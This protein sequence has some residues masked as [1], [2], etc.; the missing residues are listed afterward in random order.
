MSAYVWPQSYLKHFHIPCYLLI[1][2]VIIK[3]AEPHHLSSYQSYSVA[4][5]WQEAIYISIYIY[6]YGCYY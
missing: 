2:I 1:I 5:I 4:L 6:V 3:I